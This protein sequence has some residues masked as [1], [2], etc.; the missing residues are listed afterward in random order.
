RARYGPEFREAFRTTL[1]GLPEKERTILCLFYL[2]GLTSKSIGALYR[3]HSATV[4]RWIDQARQRILEKTHAL[5]RERLDLPPS[6]LDSLLGL[7]Q[8]QLD[9]SISRYLRD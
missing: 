9:L 3:V 1:A 5:L 4:R 7:I 2:D 6:E 8:S